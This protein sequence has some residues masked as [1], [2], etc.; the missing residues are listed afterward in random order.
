MTPLS[1][2]RSNSVTRCNNNGWR[3]IRTPGTIASTHAFQASRER[4]GSE[5]TS[6]GAISYVRPLGVPRWPN[7]GDCG[8]DSANELATADC[9]KG[10]DGVPIDRVAAAIMAVIFA[11]GG[12]TW[13]IALAW[14]FS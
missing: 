12:A 14:L 7:S 1:L 9:G 11:L 6:V 8:P 10:L 5:R 13:V 4:A 2:V 3:G